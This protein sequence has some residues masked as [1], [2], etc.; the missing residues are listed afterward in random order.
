[1]LFDSFYVLQSGS[2]A[3][4]VKFRKISLTRLYTARLGRAKAGLRLN[5]KEGCGLRRRRKAYDTLGVLS[6]FSGS[7]DVAAYIAGV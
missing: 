4:H 3:I 5:E 1:M 7:M 2:D 6:R